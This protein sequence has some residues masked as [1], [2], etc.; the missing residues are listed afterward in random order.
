MRKLSDDERRE[1]FLSKITVRGDGCWSRDGSHSRGYAIF[2][3][4]ER[5]VTGIRYAYATFVGPI[6]EGLDVDHLCRNR[7]CCNPEHGEPVTR[8]ENVLRGDGPRL[9]RVR[10]LAMTHCTQGHEL[11]PENTYPRPDGLRRC[12]TCKRAKAL[13]YY[14]QKKGVI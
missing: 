8:S 5:S 9:V 2:W 13:L 11:T 4:G 6:P 1:H 7:W 12:L 10:A 3:D 14:R